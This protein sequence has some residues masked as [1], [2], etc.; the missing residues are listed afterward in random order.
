MLKI[1]DKPIL[2]I[3]IEQFIENGF[4]DFYISVNYLKEQIME[5]FGDGK[6][7]NIDIKYL[8]EKE[9]LG[10]AGAIFVAQRNKEAVYCN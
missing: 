9:P 8:I 10:T 2:E 7:W 6:K 4:S 5:Y 3:L 1:G